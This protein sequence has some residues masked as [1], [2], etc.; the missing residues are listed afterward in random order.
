MSLCD[1]VC[2]FVNYIVCLVFIK[3]TKKTVTWYYV[4]VV[5]LCLVISVVLIVVIILIAD[6]I[7]VMHDVA[8]YLVISRSIVQLEHL[9]QPLIL[10]IWILPSV[11]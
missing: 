10:R 7:V 5:L 1:G 6:C 3:R 11:L 9:G 8:F 4:C 2:A